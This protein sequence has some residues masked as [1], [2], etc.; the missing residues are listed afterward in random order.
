MKY[1]PEWDEEYAALQE[2]RTLLWETDGP[3]EVLTS[4][5]KKTRPGPT[6]ALDIGCGQGTDLFFM[7]DEGITAIG[8]DLSYP[9]LTVASGRAGGRTTLLVQC[10][11]LALPFGECT[12]DFVNDRGCFHHIA[13][14][15]R[16]AYSREV[17]RVMEPSGTFFLR[18]FS[19]EYF[20]QGGRGFELYTAGIRS[21]FSPYFT[22]EEMNDYT[23]HVDS[24]PVAM[25]WTLMIR[26][27]ER[28]DDDQE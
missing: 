5:L 8:C 17:A 2:G 20:Q 15:L 19:E 9:A 28:S 14:P 16:E 24:I 7:R 6:R 12:F 22:I 27:Y 21:I 11:T 18:T 1:P 26:R 13:P 10:D 25:S 3:E 23:S 4:L